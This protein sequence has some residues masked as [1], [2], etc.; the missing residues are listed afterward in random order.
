MS[1]V[2]YIKQR[3]GEVYKLDIFMVLTVNYDEGTIF[4]GLY[5]CV[6]ITMLRQGLAATIT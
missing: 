3:V 6:E 1:G 5:V 4:I 2:P